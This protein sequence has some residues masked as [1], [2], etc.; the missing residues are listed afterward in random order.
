MRH[1]FLTLL[2]LILA[3]GSARAQWSKGYTQ[4]ELSLSYG[5]YSG[6]M[7]VGSYEDVEQKSVVVSNLQTDD[8]SSIGAITA[9]FLHRN[10]KKF[11]YGAALSYEQTKADCYCKLSTKRT[12][13]LTK[14]GELSCR[15]ISVMALMRFNWVEKSK[16]AFYSKLGGGITV[17]GDSYDNTYS[18]SVSAG[19]ET[20]SISDLCQSKARHGLAFQVSPAGFAFGNVGSSKGGFCGFVELGIGMH[21][22]A[23]AGV[24]YKF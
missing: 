17:V 13:P 5:Y 23:Q 1:F 6:I 14:M 22:M 2:S 4:N 16:F 10:S 20:Y 15:Y 7:M 18:G 12:D 8:R 21:G 3:L 24:A 9:Q 19:G 11:S